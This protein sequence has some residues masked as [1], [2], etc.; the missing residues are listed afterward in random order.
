[1]SYNIHENI[2]LTDISLFC[3]QLFDYPEFKRKQPIYLSYDLYS[4]LSHSYT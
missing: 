4:Y 3:L 2:L 1:M